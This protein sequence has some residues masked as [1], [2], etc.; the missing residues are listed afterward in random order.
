MTPKCEHHGTAMRESTQRPGTYFCTQKAEG[1]N[2][3]SKGYC[4]CQWYV[5]GAGGT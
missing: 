4:S 3:N 5:D 1:E 2:A